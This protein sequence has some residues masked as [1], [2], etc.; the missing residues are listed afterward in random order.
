MGEFRFWAKLKSIKSEYPHDIFPLFKKLFLFTFITG[1]VQM[2]FLEEHLWGTA[3]AITA[4]ICLTKDWNENII[5][6]SVTAS[7]G[8]IISK[9]ISNKENLQRGFW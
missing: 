7:I 3:S 4:N 9:S 5:G 1:I 6:A 8:K 2:I